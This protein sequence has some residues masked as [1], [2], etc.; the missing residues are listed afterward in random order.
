MK[1][2]FVTGLVIAVACVTQLLTVMP[3]GSRLCQGDRCGDYYWGA[4][5]HDGIWHLA[6]I[7]STFGQAKTEFPTMAGEKL[8]GYNALLDSV[9]G[10]VKL[11]THFE[12]KTLYFKVVPL[13]WLAAMIWV[14]SRFAKS[15]RTS[16]WYQAAWLTREEWMEPVGSYP[17]SRHKC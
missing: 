12:A 3:S 11:L 15:Y 17:C 10:Q 1:F 7:N 8:R 2:R 14:W 9:L 16:R 5:E 6:L 4:H 13:L